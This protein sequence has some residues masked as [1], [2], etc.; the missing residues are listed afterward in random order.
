MTNRFKAVGTMTPDKHG[1]YVL[2]ADY[3]SVWKEYEYVTE[4]LIQK[5]SKNIELIKQAMKEYNERAT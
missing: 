5:D 4:Y 2:H 3:A 1:G